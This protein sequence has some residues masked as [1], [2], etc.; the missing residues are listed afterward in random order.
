LHDYGIYVGYSNSQGGS[1]FYHI[2]AENQF[3]E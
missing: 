3:I 1:L 2:R